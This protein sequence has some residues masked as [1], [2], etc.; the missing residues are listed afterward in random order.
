LGISGNLL[1]VSGSLL[2][3]SGSLLG[4]FL[5]TSC[6]P[7]RKAAASATAK[8]QLVWQE[9]FNY[10]G[11]PDSSKWRYERG[12]VRNKEPQYYTVRRPENAMVE[13]GQLVISTLRE[14]Y[15][16]AA[17]TSA[18]LT[19]RGKF[20]FGYGRL[21]IR[22]KLPSGSGIWPAIWM[23]G[24]TRPWPAGGE[25]DIME[26]VGS[27]TGTIQATVHAQNLDGTLSSKG[28]SFDNAVSP[29]RDFHIYAIERYK[30][31][32]DFFFDNHKYFTYR[33][34]H[35]HLQ[36]DEFNEP[37]YLLLNTALKTQINGEPILDEG[38]FPQYFY[39]D[40]VRYYTQ[41]E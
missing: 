7:G 1:G 20:A 6:N 31:R 18:S 21:E 13:N 37:F 35:R 27:D 22:A 17:Y 28:R 24:T 34:A 32:M 16:G 9:E 26:Y 12:L 14:P 3:I 33:F 10:T 15:R 19:T 39:V 2:G 5:L 11:L 30:D 29:S 38:I 41:K 40:Y 8:W 25:I 23:L 4:A 36:P